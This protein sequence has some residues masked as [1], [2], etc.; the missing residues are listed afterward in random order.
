VAPRDLAEA[1]A[2]FEIAQ[3]ASQPC[4]VNLQGRNSP[5]VRFVGDLLER[6]YVG[7]VLSTSVIAAAGSPWGLE[8]VQR[9]EVMYRAR[10]ND[11]TVLSIP[12]AHMLDTLGAI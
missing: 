10:E 9:P 12:V 1:E 11:A 7:R 8:T 5:A 3:G 6:S 2:L 4:F